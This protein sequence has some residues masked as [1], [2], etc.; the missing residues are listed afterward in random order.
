[1][2]DEHAKAIVWRRSDLDSDQE[3]DDD[4]DEGTDRLFAFE[5]SKTNEQEEGVT[6]HQGFEVSN[7][8]VNKSTQIKSFQICNPLLSLSKMSNDVSIAPDILRPRLVR[9]E[10]AQGII[11]AQYVAER[12]R[13]YYETDTFTEFRLK[14]I[15]YVVILT[16]S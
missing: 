11:T 3:S 9:G 13:V 2:S 16:F 12:R 6:V 4:E 15:L 8:S 10:I 14:D 1:M 7:L 5:V